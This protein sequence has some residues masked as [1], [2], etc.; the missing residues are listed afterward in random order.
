[1]VAGCMS[2]RSTQLPVPA[3]C[4]QFASPSSPRVPPRRQVWRIL[5][6]ELAA[7]L[8]LGFWSPGWRNARDREKSV[9]NKD[10]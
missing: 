7:T 6:A 9:A 5:A 4:L 10:N 2:L 8:V 1:M 3:L